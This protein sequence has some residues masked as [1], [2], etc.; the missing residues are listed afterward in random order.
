MPSKGFTTKEGV[1]EA[2]PPPVMI[3]AFAFPPM[4][5]MLL[6]ESQGNGRTLFSF[7]SR[8]ML[9][10]AKERISRL[11]SSLS[12]ILSS[13]S[14][15]ST[16]QELSV[17]LMS[18]KYIDITYLWCSLS[19]LLNQFEY[20]PCPTFNSFEGEL[21]RLYGPRDV[22]WR[23]KLVHTR[24]FQI[25]SSIDRLSH[26]IDSKPVAYY[27]CVCLPLSSQNLAQKEGIFGGMYSIHSVISR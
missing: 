5:A 10:A 19:T 1:K 13:P 24:H 16:Y 15:S 11:S 8:T 3:S 25:D 2:D 21:A 6:R 7:L 18:E 9:W 20:F 26:R 4:M 22:V 27:R 12:S 17:S 23:A 14:P